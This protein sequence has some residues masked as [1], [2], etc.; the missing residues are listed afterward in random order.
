MSAAGRRLGGRERCAE[1]GGHP[2][3]AADPLARLPTVSLP[4]TVLGVTFWPLVLSIP[5]AIAFMPG[6]R[7][8]RHYRPSFPGEGVG[9]KGCLLGQLQG[10]WPPLSVAALA[11]LQ[12]QLRLLLPGHVDRVLRH[13]SPGHVDPALPVSRPSRAEDG[14]D[15]QQ[16]SLWGQGQ[17]RPSWGGGREGGEVLDRSGSPSALALAF[18]STRAPLSSVPTV[19]SSG[20]SPALRA[21]WVWSRGQEP[22]AGAACGPSGLTHWC[23]LWACWALP[24]SS[25]S[26]SWP[27]RAA[28][29]GPM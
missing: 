17:V 12:P 13:R 10:S 23:V 6:T 1:V 11:S 5:V 22:H 29:W 24:S 9:E 2:C 19:S 26:S 20:P 4:P 14:G 7:K 21:F 3:K 16:P 28:S 27:P 25:A 15:V 8:G 18:L